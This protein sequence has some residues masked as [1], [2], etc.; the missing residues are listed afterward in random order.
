MA[1]RGDGGKRDGHAQPTD[2]GAFVGKKHL[3]FTLLATGVGV[4]G[5]RPITTHC[6]I[7]CIVQ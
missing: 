7:Q 1:T 5:T 3:G 6:L 2:H 4:H